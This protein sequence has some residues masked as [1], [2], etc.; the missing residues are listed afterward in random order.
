MVAAV[1]FSFSLLRA[2][3]RGIGRH[4]RTCVCAHGAS[5]SN[6]V[7]SA[8]GVLRDDESVWPPVFLG[9]RYGRISHAKGEA[10]RGAGRSGV[11]VPAIE[12]WTERGRERV[13]TLA[14]ASYTIGSDPSS[15]DI[16]LDDAAVSRVHA[17]LERVGSTWLVRDLGSRNGTRLGRKP[18]TGQRRLRDGEEIF[19]GRTR[20]VFRDAADARRPRTDVIEDRPRT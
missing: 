2:A 5:V 16:G 14:E 9:C 11:A 19:V 3:T 8:H 10:P 1:S 15:A 20:L 18:L 4:S 12:L 6:S 7:R 13:V 17:I